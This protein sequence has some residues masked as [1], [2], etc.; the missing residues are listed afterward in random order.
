[1]LSRKVA[2]GNLSSV[3]FGS[4]GVANGDSSLGGGH[5][6]PWFSSPL[7]RVNFPSIVLWPG[8]IG[9]AWSLSALCTVPLYFMQLIAF[10][11][12]FLTFLRL[13]LPPCFVAELHPQALF[14]ARSDPC[15]SCDW[16]LWFLPMLL[17]DLMV[18]WFDAGVAAGL[19]LC[20]FASEPL[21]C[22]GCCC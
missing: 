7:V 2:S 17:L 4:G 15:S 22:C 3:N 11:H 5:A 10:T 13:I 21:V 12:A 1:M 9:F 19:L 20:W 18:C 16:L 6:A 14:H 8:V